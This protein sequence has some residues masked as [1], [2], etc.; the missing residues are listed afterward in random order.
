[1]PSELQWWLKASF[2]VT[3]ISD[4]IFSVPINVLTILE[5]NLTTGVVLVRASFVLSDGWHTNLQ[6]VGY[7]ND[8][9]PFNWLGDDHAFLVVAVSTTTAS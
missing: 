5:I 9:W 6:M 3:R 4:V 8:G 2:L 1:M 7:K